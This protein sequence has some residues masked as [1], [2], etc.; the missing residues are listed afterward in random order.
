MACL[1]KKPADRPQSAD[2]LSARLAAVPL[3]REWSG[4]RARG[5]WD[6]HRPCR[7]PGLAGAGG[8]GE[9]TA[10][11][12]YASPAALRRYGAAALRRWPDGSLLFPTKRGVLH[13]PRAQPGNT[14]DTEGA[15]SA[16]QPSHAAWERVEEMFLGVAGPPLPLLEPRG[17]SGA[18][19]CEEPSVLPWLLGWGG[20]RAT[21][22]R[23][24]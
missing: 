12:R 18:P 22:R 13:G 5:W 7:R 10:L 2:E 11:R 16:R 3:D 19:N 8:G 24:V 23:S 9:V 15:R 17:T 4:D 1:A 20:E 6:R 14:E 21:W